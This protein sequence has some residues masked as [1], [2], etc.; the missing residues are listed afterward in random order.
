MTQ[1]LISLSD[2]SNRVL[3]MVK[4]KFNLKDKSQAVEAVIEHYLE[5]E[6]EPN[7]REE[8]IERIKKAEKGKFVRV[9]NFAKHYGV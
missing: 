6:G 7:L 1:A 3:N 8:F 5:C 2:D 9:D 4:A